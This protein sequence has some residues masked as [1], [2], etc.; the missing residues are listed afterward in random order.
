MSKLSLWRAICLVCVFGT[1]AMIGW[2]ADTFTTLVSFNNT[3]G[4]TPLYESLAQGLNGNFYGTTSQGGAHSAG[5]VFE[6]TPAGTLTTVYN[7]CSDQHCTDGS[8]PYAG[9]IQTPNG[10]FYGTTAQGG[11]NGYGTVFE[12]TSTG[13]LTTLYSFCSQLNCADGASPEAGLVQATNGNFY[14][15]TEQNDV[16]EFGVGQGTIFEITPAGKLTTLY[17]FCSQPHC[18]DGAVPSGALIQGNNG[19][20]FGTTQG[21]G[22]S[23]C[24]GGCGIVFEIT[25]AGVLTILH[26]FDGTDGAYPIGG[27]VQATNGNFYGTTE[28][29]GVGEFGV[30]QGTV[31]E[32]T[33]G[34]T[35]TMLYGFCSQPGCTDGRFPYA[36][37]VQ[38]SNGNLYGTTMNGGDSNACG[39]HGCGSIFEITAEGRLTTLYSFDINDG[40]LLVATPV[41]G[42]NGNFYG[43]TEAG[44]ASSACHNGTLIGCGTVFR[45]SLGLT[46]FVQTLSTSGKPGAAIIVLGNNLTSTT[47]VSFNGAL[48]KFKVVSS[49]EITATVPS[50]STSGPVKVTTPD[51]TLLS[52][53]PFRVS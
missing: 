52:K 36:G 40:P 4:A 27:L 21:G 43:T 48:A 47:S 51:F 25:P 5:T 39:E 12:I 8:G 24:S 45:L 16:S 41:Q 3:D 19:N 9:L 18:T 20:F 33:P 14:G 32:I 31:F 46:P 30:D 34:G 23:A 53:V 35:L 42:T 2:A 22:N 29:G 15:T 50:N 26:A 13:T 49:T 11:A 38:A 28:Q 6:I 7:F 37:L 1:L 10:N 17:S 44:G